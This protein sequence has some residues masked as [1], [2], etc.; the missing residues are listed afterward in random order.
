MHFAEYKYW[1]TYCRSIDT[2]KGY[3]P[4]DDARERVRKILEATVD[5]TVLQS[6]W[7]STSL[8]DPKTKYMVNCLLVALWNILFVVLWRV[9]TTEMYLWNF[10]L[11]FYVAHSYYIAYW[12]NDKNSLEIEFLLCVSMPLCK[13]VE[14]IVQVS[15]LITSASTTTV[16][17]RPVSIDDIGPVTD[18][19][20]YRQCACS[21]GPD[22]TPRPAATVTL[23]IRNS[24]SEPWR[25]GATDRSVS[26]H[27]WLY[28]AVMADDGRQ[29]AFT[30][31]VEKNQWSND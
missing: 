2:K 1:R 23:H 31:H 30:K 27:D 4:P 25:G 19:T 28:L 26:K 14:K 3:K 11:M 29:Q 20:K 7:E 22:G 13:L 8:S 18:R 9:R 5:A 24:T 21:P 6:E 16:R 10:R 12:W 15:V 17:G